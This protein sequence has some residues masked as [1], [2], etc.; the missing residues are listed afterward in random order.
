MFKKLLIQVYNIIKTTI[1]GIG[2]NLEKKKTIYI[3]K[4]SRVINGS[5]FELAPNTIIG[6]NS[7]M[8]VYGNGKLKIGEGSNIGM[9]GMMAAINEIHI[10]RNVLFGPNVY[11]ADYNHCYEDVNMPISKQNLS[12]GGR[13]QI[14]DD[15]WIGKNVVIV[16]NVTI[17]KHCVIGANSF[18]NKDIPDYSVAVGNPCKVIKRYEFGINQWVRV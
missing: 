3:G 13:I 5:K 2:G 16:G 9:Y 18:V 17:G 7:Y 12:R 6:K 14:G 10:G 1:C 15:S 4:G 11:I 8:A